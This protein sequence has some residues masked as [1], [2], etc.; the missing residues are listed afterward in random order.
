FDIHTDDGGFPVLS[1]AT[2]QTLGQRA[3]GPGGADLAHELHVADV[4][5]HFQGAR[6]E[7]GGGLWRLGRFFRF[8]S[9]T[10]SKRA[11]VDTKSVR[12]TPSLRFLTDV[13][14]DL[15]DVFFGVHEYESGLAV[16]GVEDIALKVT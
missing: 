9:L 13:I 15:L 11:M 6:A 8:L 12:Q 2:T 16:E 5:A 3:D 1:P 14:R 10:L 7:C 4:D